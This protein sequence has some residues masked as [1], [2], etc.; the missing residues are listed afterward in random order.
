MR[1]AFI[2]FAPAY[3][4]LDETLR[5]L[6]PLLDQCRGADLIVLP[7]LCNSGYNF[8][9]RDDAL[10]SAVSLDGGAFVEHTTEQC[11][12][13]DCEIV[14]GLNEQDGDRLYNSAAL[15]SS[16]GV[17][18]VYRKLH[19]FMNEKDIFEPG[20]RGLPVFD[21]PYG[22]VGIQICFDWAF[23]ESWRVLAVK[24][25]EI[26]AHPSNLVIPGKCQRAMPVY[27]MTNRVFIAT[28]NRIGTERDLTFTGR[29]L[30]VAPSGD[31]LAEAPS[32]EPAVRI[33]EIDPADARDK[34]LTPRNDALT[35]RRPEEYT[36][37]CETKIG[38]AARPSVK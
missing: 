5:R 6:D 17:V 35:D 19:L 4:D 21:R 13:L 14:A 26:I 20:D 36:S 32:G 8:A 7:E 1:I 10:A 15:I 24:G 25:A 11:A 33:V 27:A 34:M 16:N 23:C 12:Q 38:H 37:L 22:R 3:C 29:S 2:Q 9:S 18:G 28:A 30:I 31:V